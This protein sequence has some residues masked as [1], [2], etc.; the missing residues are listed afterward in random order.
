MPHSR[1][2]QG[3]GKENFEEHVPDEAF[4]ETVYESLYEPDSRIVNLRETKLIKPKLIW[5]AG[6]KSEGE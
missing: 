1:Q 2:L 4:D 5:T 6:L 3:V